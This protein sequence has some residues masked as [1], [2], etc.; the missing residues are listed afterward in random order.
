MDLHLA[1]KRALI[2]GASKGL[3]FGAA[4]ALA[5]EGCAVHLVSR[6][7][8]DLEAAAGEIKKVSDVDVSFTALD[9]TKPANVELLREQLATT[10]ILVNNAGA[11]PLGSI[12]DF[13][14]QSW[15]DGWDLK[16][17]GYI[18]MTRLA[19]QV[20]KPL[21][22]PGVIVNVIGHAGEN[23][24]STYLAGT[25]GCAA[26]MAL[27]RSLGSVSPEH[28]IRV[29]GLNPGPV[30]TE[31]LYN[32]LRKRAELTL[33]DAEK[34]KQLVASM[35]FGRTGKVEEIANAVAFLASD[36]S[37]YT[38]GTIITIDG[39]VSSRAKTWL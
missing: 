14:D 29:V 28:N 11:V 1:G 31:R 24:T 39:G 6:S 33:G 32:F 25:S 30:L 35:P 3:G 13:D 36:L 37:G 19:F 4:K 17:F 26:L 5:L 2:T 21:K 20:W 8:S 15:R 7:A 23:L 34:W 18:N 9:L 12:E 16:V 10:D 38:T 22:R 27:T